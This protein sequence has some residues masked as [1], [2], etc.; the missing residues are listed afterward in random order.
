MRSP[1][2]LALVL[3]LV[4]CDTTARETRDTDEDAAA[5]ANGAA[6]RVQIERLRSD[7]IA[8]A[9]RD[10]AA[11]IAPMYVDDAVMVGSGTPPARGREAIQQALTQGFPMS[12]NLRVTSHDL[13]VSGDVAYDY[14]EFS[15]EFTPPRGR[16]QTRTGHYV[17]V[18][19]RQSDGNWKIVRHISTFPSS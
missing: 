7:W 15:E 16:A 5:P 2:L 17:V 4:A 10:D 3:P 19:K 9:E 8:A 12:R 6:A 13:T 14:G 18:L 11:T 1:L